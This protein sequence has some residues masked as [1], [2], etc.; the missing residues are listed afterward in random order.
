[1]N[2]QIP[3]F[4]EQ[5]AKIIGFL[6]LKQFLFIAAAVGLSFISYYLFNLFLWFMISVIL[7]GFALSLA[8]V[9]IHGQ[10]LPKIFVAALNYLWQPRL[11][12]WRRILRETSLEISEVAKLE[13]VRRNMS[14]QE[15]LK[16]VALSLA[17]GK[18]FSDQEKKDGTR[19]Q[20]VTYVT[21][22]RKMA[23]RVDY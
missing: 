18:I 15:K 3:Q 16:S 17:T 23:K 22:E 14:I 12:T 5:E 6:T 9:K 20:A 4:I 13:A 11:F 21:G 7:A 8:F 19:Y 10:D 2:F 1:M